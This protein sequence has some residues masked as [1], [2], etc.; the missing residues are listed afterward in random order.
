MA[1]RTVKPAEFFD[2]I[3]AVA[4]R[5]KVFLIDHSYGPRV[6][7]QL[8]KKGYIVMRPDALEDAVFTGSPVAPVV[9]LFEVDITPA[10]LRSLIKRFNPLFGCIVILKEGFK[11]SLL[12]VDGCA[13]VS[14]REF[15]CTPAVIRSI[16]EGEGISATTA[17]HNILSELVSASRSEPFV[18]LEQFVNYLKAGGTVSN[19]AM[20]TRA[21]SDYNAFGI[22]DRVLDHR[23]DEAVSILWNMLESESGNELNVIGALTW[24]LR[25]LAALKACNSPITP[26]TASRFGIKYNGHKY[27]RLASSLSIEQIRDSIEYLADADY[28]VKTTSENPFSLLCRAVLA[29]KA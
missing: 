26:E 8:E 10:Q 17:E 18:A 20:L 19:A 12:L 14:D 28:C 1:V 9:Y 23:F 7:S 13:Y 25:K 4:L 6:V 24:F 22:V 15:K 11:D 16:L 21:E 2:Y 29:L 27:V 5:G 3:N